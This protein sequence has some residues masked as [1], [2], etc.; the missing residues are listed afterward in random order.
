MLEVVGACRERKSAS[1]FYTEKQAAQA[2]RSS[3]EAI[4]RDEKEIEEVGGRVGLSRT[5]RPLLVCSCKAETRP[6][7]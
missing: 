4:F 3:I 2:R 5:A 1:S 7:R 6:R